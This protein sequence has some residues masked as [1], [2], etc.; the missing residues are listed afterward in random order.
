MSDRRPER[1]SEYMS[2]RMP[3]RMSEY[4]SD[5]LSGYIE[6]MFDYTSCWGSHEVK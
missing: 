3:D 5:S 4:M 2:D 1:M 6:Y